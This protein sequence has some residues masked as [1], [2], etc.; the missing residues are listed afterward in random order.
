MGAVKLVL[1][2]ARMAELVRSPYGPVGRHLIERATVFQAAAKAQ[3]PRRT[4]CLADSIVKRVEDHGSSFLIRVVCDTT[5]CS[6]TR[7]SYALYVHDGTAPHDIFAKP[8]GVLAFPGAD[9]STVFATHV[10]HPGTQANRFLTDN[11]RIFAA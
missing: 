9:G 8:G 5:P 2:G 7:A 1:D 6:P 11:L 10:H 4:G 3:A